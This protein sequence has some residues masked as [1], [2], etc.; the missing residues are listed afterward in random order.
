M[1]GGM[2]VGPWCRTWTLQGTATTNVSVVVHA[3]PNGW[4]QV[5]RAPSVVDQLSRR[6]RLLL[7]RR[8]RL[9]KEPLLLTAEEHQHQHQRWLQL[10]TEQTPPL[11]NLPTS[12]ILVLLLFSSIS[13]AH[14]HHV[15]YNHNDGRTNERMNEWTTIVTTTS[16]TSAAASNTTISLRPQLFDDSDNYDHRIA[17]HRISSHCRRDGGWDN[18]KA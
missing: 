7:W 1:C 14:R 17:S 11:S 3:R 6:R 2:D 12:P 16:T 9:I 15:Y 5:T 13:E 4:F 8:E 10:Q 18:L